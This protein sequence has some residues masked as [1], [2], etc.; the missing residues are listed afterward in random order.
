[1]RRLLLSGSSAAGKAGPA[2]QATAF[3]VFTGGEPALQLDGELIAALHSNGF[4]VAIETNGTLP[5]P[6]SLDW[7][8]VSPKAGSKLKV[9]SGNELKVVVPQA[10]IDLKALSVLEFQYFFVQPMD[11]P[12][13][14]QN[15]EE[16]ILYCQENPQWRLSIQSH[17][18]LGIA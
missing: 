6:A 16:A 18:Y 8:C 1:M 4:E 12:R 11:G 9:M 14:R 5:L 13:L 15:T 10:G 17:K 3:V 7:V 2:I